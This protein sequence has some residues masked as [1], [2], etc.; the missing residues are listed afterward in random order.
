MLPG[1]RAPTTVQLAFFRWAETLKKVFD[2]SHSDVGKG[3]GRRGQ[4]QHH[5]GEGN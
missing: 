4:V 5:G 2:V 3:Q 1:G